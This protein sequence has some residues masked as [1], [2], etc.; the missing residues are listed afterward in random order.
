MNRKFE[1]TEVEQDVFEKI[2]RIMACNT[3]LTHP[4]FNETFRIHAD[5]SAFQLR[6]VISDNTNVESKT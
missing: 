3:L 2:K 4:D 6:A 1:W 5:A